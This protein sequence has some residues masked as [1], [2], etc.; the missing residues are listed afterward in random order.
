M[1]KR[2]D[3]RDTLI[4]NEYIGPVLEQAP[5]MKSMPLASRTFDQGL[6]DEIVTY[7]RNAVNSTEEGVSYEEAFK[8]AGTGVN[9]V[10]EKYNIQ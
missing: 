9:Q 10:L 1:Y 8:K 2:Q 4:Q 5:Y 6:N 3:L 7:L